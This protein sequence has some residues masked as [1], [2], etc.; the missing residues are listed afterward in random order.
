MRSDKLMRPPPAYQVYASDD[1]AKT[2][3]YG[4]SA[5][6]RGVLDSM[7]R[8]YW[9]EGRLPTDTRLLALVLRLDE[10]E[11][12]KHFTDAVRRHF[13]SDDGDPAVL[14]SIEL[15]RQKL[16]NQARREQQSKG[17]K[18]GAAITN[19]NRNPAIHGLPATQPAG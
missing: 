14:H 3:Y 5:G 15:R 13:E 2:D 17:G 6:E 7:Q 12:H 19:R 11:V 10:N 16:E 4:L 18:A 8:V 1:L 9:V